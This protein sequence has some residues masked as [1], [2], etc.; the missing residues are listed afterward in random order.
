MAASLIREDA[1]WLYELAMEVY[2][3]VKSDDPTAIQHEMKRLKRFSEFF[4]HGP[5]MEE[6][7]FAESKE[8]YMFCREFPRMIEHMLNRVLEEKK[9]HLQRRAQRKQPDQA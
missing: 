9:L 2:R 3:A 6:F 1:P 4:M 7:G 8:A 5:F